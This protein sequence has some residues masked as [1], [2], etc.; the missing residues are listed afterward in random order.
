MSHVA[1]CSLFLPK[2]FNFINAF[3]CYKQ[4]SKLVPFNLAHRVYF[5]KAVGLDN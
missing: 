1:V 5:K 2:S 3:A 4:K